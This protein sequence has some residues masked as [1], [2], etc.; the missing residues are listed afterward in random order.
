CGGTHVKRTGDIGYFKIVSE[1]A[2]SSGVRRLEVLTGNAAWQYSAEQENYLIEAASAIKAP[3]SELPSRLA[4]LISE[5]KA[6][7]K[8]IADLQKKVALG[9]GASSKEDEIK[10]IGGIK[11]IGRVLDGIPAKELRGLADDAKKRI[12]SGVIA[13]IAV[14]DGKAAVLTA[15]T[16]DLINKISAVDLVRIGAGAVGGSGGGGRPDMAQ[17]GGPDGT[18][19]HDALTAIEEHLS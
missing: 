13:F 14:N 7:E 16:D 15:V 17:A 19:A 8:E 9:G 5:R 4:N 6:M 1:S 12:G 11:F 18:K 3:V 10:D 2:V